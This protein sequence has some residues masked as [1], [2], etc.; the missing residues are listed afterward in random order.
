MLGR[1]HKHSRRA[2]GWLRVLRISRDTGIALVIVAALS[3]GLA[4]YQ[5]DAGAQDELPHQRSGRR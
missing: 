3:S 5:R 2:G 4:A 1:Q